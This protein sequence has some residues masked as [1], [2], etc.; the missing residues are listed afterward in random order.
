MVLL[1]VMCIQKCPRGLNTHL[2]RRES[3]CIYKSELTGQ[4][5]LNNSGI[6]DLCIKSNEYRYFIFE[7]KSENTAATSERCLPAYIGVSRR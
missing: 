7:F 5:E 2:R 4:R 3:S 6:H 1:S